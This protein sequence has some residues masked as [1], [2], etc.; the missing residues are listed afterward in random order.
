MI[1]EIKIINELMEEMIG[2]G[3]KVI[4][5]KVIIL[6]STRMITG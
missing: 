2:F 5:L 1:Q 4:I 6:V 3:K